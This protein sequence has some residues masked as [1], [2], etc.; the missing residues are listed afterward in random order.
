M[1]NVVA[2]ASQTEYLRHSP[3][4]LRLHC[5]ANSRT[6]HGHRRVEKGHKKFERRLSRE[7]RSGRSGCANKTDELRS[8]VGNSWLLPISRAR[9]LKETKQAINKTR[10]GLVGNWK[11]EGKTIAQ[12]TKTKTTRENRCS[13]PTTPAT[14]PRPFSFLPHFAKHDS[15]V[16]SQVAREQNIKFDTPFAL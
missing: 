5:N 8:R 9:H 4:G 10:K 2:H 13:E 1:C 16:D 3:D 11:L 12:A 15:R 14:T 6:K 7:D